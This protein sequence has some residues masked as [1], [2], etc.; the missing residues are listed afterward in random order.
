MRSAAGALAAL[1]IVSGCSPQPGTG[2]GTT[3]HEHAATMARVCAAA[4]PLGA[5]PP[6]VPAWCVALGR[7]VD[8]AAPGPNSWTDEFSTGATNARIPSAYR[9]FD[10][11]RSR[12]S[13]VFR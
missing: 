3:V 4:T 5:L 9:V 1:L 10:L 7:A 13:S 6:A 2:Q 8:S 12:A 11:A